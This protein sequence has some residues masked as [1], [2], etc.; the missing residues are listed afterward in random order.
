VRDGERVRAV[1]GAV[2]DL[3]FGDAAHSTVT[4]HSHQARIV[5]GPRCERPDDPSL[6]HGA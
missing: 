1:V 3:N 2:M 4:R 6:S 5:R